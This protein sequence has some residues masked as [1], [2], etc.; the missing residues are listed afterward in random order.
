MH[1]DTDI[2]PTSTGYI[3]PEA[4]TD[5]DATMPKNSVYVSETF[6]HDTR[7]WLPTVTVYGSHLLGAYLTVEVAKRLGKVPVRA[8]RSTADV[9]PLLALAAGLPVE[10]DDWYEG[11]TFVGHLEITILNSVFRDGGFSVFVGDKTICI[12][13]PG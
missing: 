11:F 4:V 12:N 8:S 3:R 7:I 6:D 5:I 2:N 13:I 9:T 1:I 10:N